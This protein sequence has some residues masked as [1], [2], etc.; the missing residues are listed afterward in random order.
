[1]TDWQEQVPT[2]GTV[3]LP[4]DPR[5]LDG[6]GRNHSLDTALADLIDNS[7]DAGATRAHIRLIR[8]RGRLQSLYVADNGKGMSPLEIDTAMTF[9]A[10][11]NYKD[12]DLGHFGIG[13]QSASFSQARA[14]TVMSR[15]EG[16]KAAGRRLA[17]EKE[18]HFHADLVPDSFVQY[19]LSQDRGIPADETRTLIRWDQVIGFPVT[20]DDVRVEEFITRSI[21]TVSGH[22]GLVFHRF[23][24]D[25]RV[26]ISMDVEDV[27]AGIT[28]P[29]FMVR[30][31]DPFG[32]KRS[33]SVGYPKELIGRSEIG[34][35]TFI[36]H[37]WSG[38]SSIPEFRL[39]G[40]AEDRQG[41]YV[42]RRDRLIQAGGDW[43]GLST[44]GKRRQLAR[45]AV[46]IND[47][48]VGLLRMNPEKSRVI[49][50]P[51]FTY[52][53][54][55][56]VAKDGTTFSTYM[57]EAEQ[58]FRESR[59]RSA[60]R[61]R[62]IPPGRGFAPSLRRAISTEVPFTYDTDEPID[63]RWK[64]LDEDDF[65]EIAWSERTLWL[66]ERYRGT[67]LGGRRGGLNDAPIVKALLYLLVEETFQGEHLG[68]RDKDNIRLWQEILTVAAKSERP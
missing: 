61:R 34:T 63:I 42:Y 13:L 68:P 35:V 31:L 48:I 43:G 14:L 29:R 27:D 39:P 3:P 47:D 56:A 15:A 1:V 24:V 67:I 55:K 54:E 36:C 21:Q 64:R 28:G 7:I 60:G 20:D 2:S 46:D 19:E 50:G 4:P 44:L 38:R 26:T 5:A 11:R 9:G 32:Y 40:G 6:L 12:G 57:E 18:A 51:E 58:A 65:F 33:G 10:R 62:R 23:L 22:L 49:A 53:A 25:E 59:K 45:V 37:I 16:Y 17:L 30:P 8:Y 66:N 41:L 52:L